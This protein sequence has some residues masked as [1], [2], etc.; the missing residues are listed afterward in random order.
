[1][2][3]L[4]QEENQHSPESNRSH[5]VFGAKKV[6]KKF[7][8]TGLPNDLGSD[9]QKAKDYAKSLVSLCK[10]VGE[11][12]NQE[13]SC[14]EEFPTDLTKETFIPKHVFERI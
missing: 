9:L 6:C 14:T 8:T 3:K 2:Q 5:L 12:E 11:G 10:Y 1:M 4:E 13:Q 7:P